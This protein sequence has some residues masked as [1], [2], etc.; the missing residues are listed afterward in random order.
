LHAVAL[1]WEPLAWLDRRR[2]CKSPLDPAEVLNVI[3]PDSALLNAKHLFRQAEIEPAPEGWTSVA[4][5]LMSGSMPAAH[6]VGDGYIYGLVDSIHHNP[7]IWEGYGP[8]FTF[9]VIA[10]SIREARR[11][12]GLPTPGVFLDIC[13]RHRRRFKR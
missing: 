7:E 3:P 2:D 1:M 11:M 6:R 10:R 8:G 9:A 12:D 4:I 13:A 5:A